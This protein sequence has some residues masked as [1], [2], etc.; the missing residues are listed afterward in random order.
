MGEPH[1]GLESYVALSR[2]VLARRERG[3]RVE[4]TLA[5]HRPRSAVSRNG[6]AA[7]PAPGRAF[8]FRSPD[9]IVTAADKFLAEHPPL[10]EGYVVPTLLTLLNGPWKGGKSTWLMALIDALTFGA[11]TFCGRALPGRPVA[12]VMLAE[13]PDIALRDK[14]AALGD[15]PLLQVLNRAGLPAPI[16]SRE[17]TMAAAVEKAHSI[18]AELLVVD[19]F[20]E[21][22]KAQDEN[23]VRD[24]QD[25]VDVLRASTSAG[26]ACLATHHFHKGW[27]ATIDDGE[28]G[29]GSTALPAAANVI[30][31]LAPV[32][33]GHPNDRQLLAQSHL[34]G[35][36]DA[37]VVRWDG[38]SSYEVVREGPRAEVR[39][40][41]KSAQVAEGLPMTPP[42]MTVNEYADAQNIDRSTAQRRLKEALRDRTDVVQ[43]SGAGSKQ[44][45][46]RYWAVPTP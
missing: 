16:P 33:G 42:G 11:Q 2:R 9:E 17:E 4:A 25:A 21:W 34:R 15:R 7:I 20:A 14:L 13:E 30:I 29:R 45:P 12:V 18:G 19:T 10:L 40:A 46:H 24:V 41:S 39:S 26:L 5:P 3:A 32:A 35:T 31:D 27:R 37:L 44:D 28:A 23:A 6:L 43:R 36:P 38:I 22:A 8:T 1:L